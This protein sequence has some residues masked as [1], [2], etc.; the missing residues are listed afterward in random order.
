MKFFLSFKRDNAE[1]FLKGFERMKQRRNFE[2]LQ[3][4]QQCGEVHKHSPREMV[5]MISQELR[6]FGFALRMSPAPH[7]SAEQN[8]RCLVE[9]DRIHSQERLLWMNRVPCSN[10]GVCACSLRVI[11]QLNLGSSD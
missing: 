11:T 4:D 5:A 9:A 10:T 8:E 2:I 1:R 6:Q 3:L 7:E